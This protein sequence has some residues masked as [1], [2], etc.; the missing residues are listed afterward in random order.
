MIFV[1]FTAQRIS[2]R[3][4]GTSLNPRPLAI[5]RSVQYLISDC[6][7][8]IRDKW[9]LPNPVSYANFSVDFPLLVMKDAMPRP[10]FL[11]SAVSAGL[12]SNCFFR[13]FLLLRPSL[14]AWTSFAISLKSVGDFFGPLVSYTKIYGSYTKPEMTACAASCGQR[15]FHEER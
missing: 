5:V 10:S 7:R 4:E 12:Y 9:P 15:T 14:L 8:T 6:P 2:E 13:P 3:K 11:S 1:V